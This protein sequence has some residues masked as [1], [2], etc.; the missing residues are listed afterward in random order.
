MVLIMISIMA[1]SLTHIGHIAIMDTSLTDISVGVAVYTGV[2]MGKAM[3]AVWGGAE[4]MAEVEAVILAVA[5]KAG[6][7]VMAVAK[8]AVIL[9]ADTAGVNYCCGIRGQLTWMSMA[10]H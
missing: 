10:F 4:V 7:E 5:G 8:E 1:T 3:M 6:E 2:V 9:A